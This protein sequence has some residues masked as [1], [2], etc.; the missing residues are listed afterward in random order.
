MK[1]LNYSP[2]KRRRKDDYKVNGQNAN[3]VNC[4]WHLGVLGTTFEIFLKFTNIAKVSHKPKWKAKKV[5]TSCEIILT[6]QS[7]RF[8][9]GGLTSNT[10]N[11]MMPTDNL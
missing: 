7:I 3:A 1:V 11:G 5:C 9:S 10:D 4:K 2:L 6:A 8:P